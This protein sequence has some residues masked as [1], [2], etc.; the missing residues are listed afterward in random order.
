VVANV[1]FTAI[2]AFERFYMRTGRITD[3]QMTKTFLGFV[4]DSNPLDTA[5]LSDQRGEHCR[6][7]T[8]LAAEYRSER[9][10]LTLAATLIKVEDSLPVTLRH[11]PW[12]AQR[13][14]NVQITEFYVAVLARHNMPAHQRRTFTLGRGGQVYAGAGALTVAALQ[15]LALDT[16]LRVHDRAPIHA[17]EKS[18]PLV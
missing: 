18:M 16:P 10:L 8:G 15:I 1:D 3:F 17:E 11:G 5:H 12:G 14:R 13:Y 2:L 4:L 9:L 6:M 7:T